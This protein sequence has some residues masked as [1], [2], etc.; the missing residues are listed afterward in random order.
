M[1]HV[2]YSPSTP[3]KQFVTC[4]WMITGGD[5]G[6]KERILPNGTSELLINLCEDEIRTYDPSQPERVKRLSG[7]VVA[8]TYSR[9]LICDAR[10]HRSMLGVHFRPGG[11]LPFLGTPATALSDAHVSLDDLWGSRARALRE[12]LCEATTARER[13]QLMEKALLDHAYP[14]PSRY[15]AIQAALRLFGPFG[16]GNSSRAVAQ[17][18][19]ISQRQFIDVF[20]RQVGLTP[21]LLCRILRFKQARILAEKVEGQN[22]EEPVRDWAQ[23]AIASGYCDQSHLIRDF[24]NLSGLSP[25]EYIRELQPMRDPKHN[26]VPPH[27]KLG[28]IPEFLAA[29][30]LQDT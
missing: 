20:A 26:R 9:A 10:Q 3:L 28:Q 29:R 11:A 4:F 8:G 23:I 2:I 1:E 18:L 6:R 7:A 14:V 12:Q 24:E 30:D 22:G 25:S 17:E 13:F 21:K 27:M 19:G 5:T 15:S 16:T